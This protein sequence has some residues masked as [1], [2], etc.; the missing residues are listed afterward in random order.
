MP[1]SDEEQIY[2]EIE[3]EVEEEF[4]DPDYQQYIAMRTAKPGRFSS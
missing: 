2:T 3:K 1:Q 4:N